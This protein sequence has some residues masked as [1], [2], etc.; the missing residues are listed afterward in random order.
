MSENP[1]AA[2]NEVSESNGP[3]RWPYF[4]WLGPVVTWLPALLL[5][6]LVA[7]GFAELFDELR[8][9]GELPALASW[10]VTVARISQALFHLPIA[11][12]LV[13]MISADVAL[14]DSARRT[15]VSWPHRLSQVAVCAS[16]MLAA[17]LVLIG[18]LLPIIKSGTV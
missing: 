7:P 6:G 8:E 11:L 5:F 4:G 14:A 17:C 18:L 1:Y 9:R 10:V 2:P 3:S 12:F 15:R 13:A 16:G